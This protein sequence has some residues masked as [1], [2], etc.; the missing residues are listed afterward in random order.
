MA[1]KMSEVVAE[2][3]ANAEYC[4]RCE[5]DFI[6]ENDKV[7]PDEQT[8]F[9]TGDADVICQNCQDADV[10]RYLDNYNA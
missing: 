10:D 4:S 7:G 3:L 1:K 2:A 9:W 8:I 6:D 5:N